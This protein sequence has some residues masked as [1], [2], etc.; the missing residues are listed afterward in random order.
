LVLV[1]VPV[2]GLEFA[3]LYERQLLNSLERDMQNQASLLRSVL[4]SSAENGCKLDDAQVEQV[5][6]RAARS[7]RTRIRVLDT[8]LVVLADSH[9][10]GPPEGEEPL[11]PRLAGGGDIG[12][13]RSVMQSAVHADG[14]V[15]ALSDRRELRRAMAGARATATRLRARPP[16]VLL[17]LAEPFSLER[18]LAGVIY[19]TRSTQPVLLEL[20]KI[21]KGLLVV[22]GIA[23]ASTALATLLL[24][25]TLTRPI[26]RL[27]RAARR[28]SHGHRGVEVPIGGGGELTELGM[29]VDEMTHQLQARHRYILEFAADVAHEFKSPLTSIRGATELLA[30]GAAEDRTARARFLQNI[31]LDT[32]RLEHL[33]ARLL[34]L[35]RIESSEEP[36]SMVELATLA[37]RAVARC[38]SPDQPIE[39]LVEANDTHI[40]GR[41]SDLEIAL[42]NLLDNALRHSPAGEPV[43]I[44]IYARDDGRE[45]CLTVADRGPGIQPEHLPKLFDRFFTT[46][47][48]TGGTGLGLAIVA[49]VAKAH[50]AAVDVESSPGQ[51]ARFTLRFS[52]RRS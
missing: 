42:L 24:A 50:S 6:T 5:L 23:M 44:E 39:L 21:R 29:A 33:V 20:H 30:E 1:L 28:I 2:V 19:L 46:Q 32:E 13:L 4:E 45:L 41:A 14:P 7:T 25:W 11:A 17:F 15:V 31:L 9:R 47:L 40:L 16:A 34:E 12:P 8:K 27:A 43:L 18:Q 10:F 36:V 3:R 51:G 52:I 26:E 48:E 22:L 35:S 38:E 37:R 49:S